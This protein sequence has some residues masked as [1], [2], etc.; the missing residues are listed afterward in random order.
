MLDETVWMALSEADKIQQ[1]KIYIDEL[2]L[3][4]EG[5]HRLS[6]SREQGKLSQI[7]KELQD[8]IYKIIELENVI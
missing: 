7:K 3:I 8:K 5:N 6:H 4:D 2:I 1:L